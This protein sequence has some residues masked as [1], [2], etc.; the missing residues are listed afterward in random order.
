[1]L[2]SK[3]R[4]NTEKKKIQFKS[5]QWRLAKGEFPRLALSPEAES[6]LCTLTRD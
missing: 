6:G 1:M 2:C 5:W 4:R 3:Q